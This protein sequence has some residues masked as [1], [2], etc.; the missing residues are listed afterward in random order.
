[1]SSFGPHNNQMQKT[2]AEAAYH[3][4]TALPASDLGRSPGHGCD[5]ID[6]DP[7]PSLVPAMVSR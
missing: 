2:G 3:G 7:M 1:M 5:L 6:M 4:D